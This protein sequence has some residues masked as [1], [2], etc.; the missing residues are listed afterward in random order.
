MADKIDYKKAFPDLYMPKT[1]PSVVDVP[2]MT[3][4]AVDG[5]GD[6]NTSKSYHEALELL[7][8]L[9]FT[10]KMSKMND[11]RPVGYFEYVV[12]PL[13]G[14][15]RVEGSEFNG[16]GNVDKSSFLWTS[17]IRQPEFVTEEVFENARRALAEKRPE[18]DTSKARLI[19]FREGLCV[20]LMHIGPYDDE[21]R[22]VRLMEEY[23]AANGLKTD[24]G[25][26][27]HHEIYLGDPRRSKPQNLKTV[28][29]HP[30]KRLI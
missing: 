27:A 9:S 20:Q 30:V 18:A 19:S 11:T 29:R 10:I 8:G 22:S 12:P 25:V 28:L 14:L 6:P 17:M 2:E 21:P 3:F 1:A 15:W 16:V 13:E 4:I 5:C 23:I 7:Y 24:L 26:R